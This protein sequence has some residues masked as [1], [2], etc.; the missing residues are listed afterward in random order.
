MTTKKSFG[1]KS[2]KLFLFSGNQSLCAA[3]RP[4][5]LQTAEQAAQ[6]AETNANIAAIDASSGVG[7]SKEVDDASETE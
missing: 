5:V 7:T 6:A 1:L 2:P 4:A 3:E